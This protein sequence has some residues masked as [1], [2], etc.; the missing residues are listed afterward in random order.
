MIQKYV[1]EDEI[2]LLELGIGAEEEFNKIKFGA[3]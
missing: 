1:V 2:K 3:V